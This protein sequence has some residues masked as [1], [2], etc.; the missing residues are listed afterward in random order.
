MRRLLLLVIALI[1]YGSLYPWHF[2]PRHLDANPFALLFRTWP[3][4]FDRYAIRDLTVNVLLYA[5][6]GATAFLAFGRRC[7]RAWGVALPMLLGLALSTAIELA[8]LFDVS[9]TASAF[10]VVCNVS[11]CGAGV[12]VASRFRKQLESAARLRLASSKAVA[13]GL[14]LLLVWIAYQLY[15]LFP[16]LSRHRLADAFHTLF[17]LGAFSFI[18]FGRSAAEWLAAGLLL[19]CAFGR[20]G[21]RPRFVLLLLALPLRMVIVQRQLALA[22]VAGAGAALLV[23]FL[24][25][26]PLR[27][28]VFP[29]S[30]RRRCAWVAGGLLALVVLRGLSP[31]HFS[32]ERGAFLWV[33]FIGALNAD[34]YTGVLVVARKAFDYGAATFLL[35]QAGLGYVPA[36]VLVAAILSVVEAVQ[37]YLPS[38]VAEITD[39][40]LA[41]LLSLVL[42]QVEKHFRRGNLAQD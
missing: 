5:P 19:E 26:L 14:L 22:E 25:V 3:M 10:D 33:P 21:A 27:G 32:A 23:L 7:G 13:G 30:D 29:R 28:S 34:P 9:R 31:F 6:L 11:G 35:W 38:H 36:T 41:V 15:P 42:W 8:Q 16:N 1:V 12:W 18:E 39:P 17:S 2:V 24:W 20:E 40:L 37:M 4:Q